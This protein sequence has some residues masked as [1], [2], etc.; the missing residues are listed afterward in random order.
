MSSFHKIKRFDLL[1]KLCREIIVPQG[2]LEEFSEEFGT[3]E[4]IIPYELNEEQ[5]KIATGLGLG[6]GESQTI[7]IAMNLGKTAVIDENQARN[8]G[9]N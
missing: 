9:K 4:S 7:A 1:Q 6:K 2:V 3:P 8:L 5:L